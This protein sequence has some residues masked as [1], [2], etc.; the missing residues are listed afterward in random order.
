VSRRLAGQDPAPAHGPA[1]GTAAIL[2]VS[3]LWGT[4]GTVSSFAPAGTNPVA[5]GA[6]GLVLGGLLLF[7]SA[8][9]A[10]TLAR[11]AA[12]GERRLLALGA[13]AVTGYP[14]S[15]Y[16]AVTRTGVAV[17]TV[18]ALG[19]APVFAGLLG[20]AAG[21]GRPTLRWVIATAAAVAG[22]ALLVAGPGLAGTVAG[23]HISVAGVALA[24]VAG[25][26]YA[27]YS[28]IGGRLIARGRPAGS[29]MGAMFGAAALLVLPVLL[30]AGTRWVATPRGVLVTLHLGLLT[31]FLAY[32]IFGFG[33]RRVSAQAATTLTLA[34]PA[35]AA[36]L[37][38]VVLAER[39]P[40]AS[41]LGL[42]VLA[43]GLAFLALPA[44]SRRAGGAGRAVTAG[45]PARR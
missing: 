42:G 27:A 19:S 30:A 25:L 41:W 12:R 8:R 4:T 26:S 37:G 11:T 5:I 29:V 40:V 3:A 28:L 43:G 20:W 45:Q 24:A 13:V 34:E 38:T 17:A 44:Q 22:C 15:F 6:A 23:A 1:G 36:V 14:L 2:A 10:W 21:Q 31:T 7:L 39:L 18:V 9:G 33:L 32:R 35:V 16:P